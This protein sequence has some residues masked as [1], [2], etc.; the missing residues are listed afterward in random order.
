M[1]IKVNGKTMELDAP[2]NIAGLAAHLHLNLAQVAV[3]RNCE[4]VP[5]SRYA[6]VEV[7]EGDAIEI[8]HFIG[9]G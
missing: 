1:Q 4:I 9:G 3:E 7:A 6:E 8:V 2:L 5:R